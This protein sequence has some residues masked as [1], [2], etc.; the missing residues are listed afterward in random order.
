MENKPVLLSTMILGPIRSE[1][2]ILPTHR[3]CSGVLGGPATYA[4]MGFRV[5]SRDP[6]GI[7]SRVGASFPQEWLDKLKRNGFSV[8]GIRLLPDPQPWIGFHAYENWRVHSESEPHRWFSSLGL[9][10]PAELIN[11]HSPTE[12]EEKKDNPP[13]IALRPEDVPLS[14]FQARAAYLAPAHLFSQLLLSVALQT[15]GVGSLMLAP[16]D[17]ILQPEATRELS[18][19]LHGIQIFFAKERSA[20]GAWPDARHHTQ[21]VAEAIA[22]LGPKIVL[23]HRGLEGVH[24]YDSNSDRHTLIPAYPVTPV[25]ITGM[26]DSFCGGFLAGWLTTFDPVESCLRGIIS[27]SLA[28]EGSGAWFTLD[29]MPGLAESR[30]GL[31]RD[32]ISR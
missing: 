3:V 30:L 13:E 26:E 28:I 32:S 7:V 25:D 11:F 23:L 15:R 20:F 12:G 6:V 16:S 31:L 4:A 29:R 14:F 21:H 1:F 10:E 22:R 8:E 19:L 5:W 18:T 9:P 24:L 27:A 17:R 2:H